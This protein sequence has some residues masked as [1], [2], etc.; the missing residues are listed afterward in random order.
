MRNCFLP[1]SACSCVRIVLNR[2]S[3]S[4]PGFSFIQ[5]I[6]L[7][8]IKSRTKPTILQAQTINHCVTFQSI[9]IR[10][11]TKT[12][13]S[14]FNKIVISNVFPPNINIDLL[15]KCLGCLKQTHTKYYGKI[16]AKITFNEKSLCK[17]NQKIQFKC[18]A[19]DGTTFQQKCN[20]SNN[21]CLFSSL[22]RPVSTR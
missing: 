18:N 5:K 11:H 1:I 13:S 9:V 19:L 8:W 17:Q 7:N 15:A 21:F 2:S 22:F 20:Q 4:E 12:I 16:A 10:L 6:H 14:Y 3:L